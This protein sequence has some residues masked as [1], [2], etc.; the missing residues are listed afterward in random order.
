MSTSTTPLVV[1]AYVQACEAL[2]SDLDESTRAQ[3]RADIVEIVSEV[4]GELD[5]APDDLVG[6]PRR[7]VGELR[8][9]AGLPPLN[10]QEQ[11]RR[12]P[13]VA[14]TIRRLAEHR[15]TRWVR[16][17]GPDLRTAWWVA[18]GVLVGWAAGWATGARGPSWILNLVPHWPVAGSALLGFGAVG[19]AVYLSVEAGRRRPQGWRRLAVLAASVVAV[20]F[21]ASTASQAS[22]WTNG[23]AAYDFV[24]PP[25]DAAVV[26]YSGPPRA[27]SPVV[28]GSHLTSERSEVLDLTTARETV[29]MLLASAPPASIYFE[30]DGGQHQPGTRQAI[31]DILVD[32]VDRGLLNDR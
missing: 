26:V 8:V 17:L 19:T 31:D 30:F 5:G 14:G 10:D 21:A 1:A 4:C 23:P 28:V 12:A 18:R 22:R 9:A 11:Q 20:V 16:S 3:L 29:D 25:T 32:L 13:G 27:F 2:L 6:T 7:F 15:S 24:G